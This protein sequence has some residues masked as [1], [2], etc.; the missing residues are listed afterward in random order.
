MISVLHLYGEGEHTRE[1]PGAEEVRRASA[2]T[3]QH[4]VGDHGSRSAPGPARTDLTSLQ[5]SPTSRFASQIFG[6]IA[7]LKIS[8]AQ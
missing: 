7:A 5:P 8:A 2:H 3:V 6:G 1:E 4:A